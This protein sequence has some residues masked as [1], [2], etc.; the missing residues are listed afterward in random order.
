MATP[1][2][3]KRLATLAV[4]I[5]GYHMV[6]EAW[7]FVLYPAVI[8]W[9]GTLWGGLTMTVASGLYC[10]ALILLYRWS[11]ID[12]LG[13][14]WLGEVRD[15]DGKGFGPFKRVVRWC[16][17]KGDI[18]AFLALAIIRDAF[19]ATSYFHR[20]SDGRQMS[21]RDW[22]VFWASLV[23][24]NAVWIIGWGGAIEGAKKLWNLLVG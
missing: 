4:G 12:F 20:K 1:S 18:P 6:D 13:L 10:Y 17:R 19:I 22:K 23:I 21:A 2:W 16:L 5:A 7:D 8:V 24:S 3:L 11:G 9:L 15:S 14:E